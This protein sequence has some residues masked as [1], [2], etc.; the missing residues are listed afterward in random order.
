MLVDVGTNA[1]VVVGNREWLIACAG[2]AGPAL[3]GGVVRIGM[4]ATEGAVER[5]R[6]DAETGEPSFHVVG[7]V[8][9]VGVCGSGLIDL[10]AGLFTA[11]LLDIR[12][13]LN[14]DHPSPRIKSTED[15]T[16]YVLAYEDE[17]GHGG[18]LAITDIDI[19][20]LIKSKAAMYTILNVVTGKVGLSFEDLHA[21]YMAGTFG[22]HIDPKAAVTIG[23]I[24][25]LPVET[26]VPLGN[27]A[28]LG[29]CLVLLDG[30][31]ME[32]VSRIAEMIY[33]IELNVNVELMT[34]FRGATFLPH[35]DRSLFPSVTAWL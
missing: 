14:R 10:V 5:V 4:T 9:P 17:T 8:K 19:S 23:M 22:N 32:E 27:S 25:D 3:E 6:I 34:T 35:T 31:R 30:G 26:Y 1:E 15:T 2:A 29:A 7:D 18:E 33:Y 11:G 24:P 12:G 28:G 16:A 20:I 13:R 21:I